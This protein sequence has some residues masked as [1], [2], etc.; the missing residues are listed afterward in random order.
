MQSVS[1]ATPLPLDGEIANGRWG[2]E[3]ARANPGKFQQADVHF[4]LPGYFETLKTPLL[5]GRTFTDADNVPGRNG[6]VIDQILAA[7][8]FPAQSAVGKRLLARIRSE[9]PE[10]LEVIGVVAHQRQASLARPGREAIYFTDAFVGY[11]AARRWLIKT[12]S[13]PAALGA[14]IRSEVARIDPRLVVAEV[15]PMQKFVQHAQAPTRFAL[16]LIG[17]FAGIAALL[18]AVGLYGVLSAAVRQRTAEIGVRMAL[19]AAPSTIFQIMVGEGLGLSAAGIV[20]GL[21]AAL[22]L[23]R[24]MISMLVDVK[25]TDPVTYASIAVLFFLMAVVASWLPARRA[26]RLDPATALREE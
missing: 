26:A 21:L 20:L 7:K 2:T 17:V 13:D 9:E 22:G 4:V 10:W 19:G 24:A 16:L 8:A 23:T 15:Q 1:A 18:A 11:G 3:E 25:P 12:A 5:A 6:I 14:A